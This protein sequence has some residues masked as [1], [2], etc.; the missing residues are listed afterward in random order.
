[1]NVRMAGLS[2]SLALR[3]YDWNEM[4]KFA[5]IKA[6]L[7][8]VWAKA[9]AAGTAQPVPPPYWVQILERGA[10][11]IREGD[12]GVRRAD[13][14][15]FV[16]RT[17][18]AVS[19]VPTHQGKI[20]V[21]DAI[22]AAKPDVIIAEVLA[23]YRLEPDAATRRIA[24]STIPFKDNLLDS[25]YKA[26]WEL[27][28]R[29]W[30][31]VAARLA[32]AHFSEAPGGPGQVV[33]R[34]PKYATAEDVRK[35]FVSLLDG[36]NASTRS[37]NDVTP[38]W[39]SLAACLESPDPAV[40]NEAA[41]ILARAKEPH[42]MLPKKFLSRGRPAT[43]RMATLT[44]TFRTTP[45]SE[46]AAQKQELSLVL[47]ETLGGAAS[48]PF[49]AEVLLSSPWPASDD[50]WLDVKHREAAFRRVLRLLPWIPPQQAASLIASFKGVNVKMLADAA[51]EW[52]E[53]EPEAS[54]REQILGK[55][56]PWQNAP[57]WRD[58]L[59][60]AAKDSDR[61]N[62]NLA[63]RALQAAESRPGAP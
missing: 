36:G 27:A 25:G 59:I 45:P 40:R 10:D 57:E 44:A 52:Y 6:A 12:V 28:G 24:V 35:A 49:L 54:V 38:L 34:D 32:S 51:V 55:A 50:A 8:P 58:L 20:H 48:P 61:N 3:T 23:W 21:F 30:D 2:R 19:R 5:E 15:M 43:V 13:S 53:V 26:V 63:Q 56:V 9:L 14:R 46:L 4:A 29:D 1:L 39:A 62:A 16:R 37:D 31:E 41:T 33:G 18:M 47:H 7:G 17:L 22:S 60:L 11:R 42:L